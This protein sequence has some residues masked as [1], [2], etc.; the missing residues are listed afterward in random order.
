MTLVDL[1]GTFKVPNGPTIDIRTVSCI[2][3]NQPELI[4]ENGI[5]GAR[6][7]EGHNDDP[8]PTMKMAA[9]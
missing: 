2:I 6:C 8:L 3:D 5:G 9:A 7:Q 1:C 4:F